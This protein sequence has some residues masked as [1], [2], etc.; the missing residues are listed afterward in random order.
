MASI[1]DRNGTFNP[2]LNVTKPQIELIAFILDYKIK[3]LS[4][5]FKWTGKKTSEC[6]STK[7]TKISQNSKYKIHF[8]IPKI[9][10]VDQNRINNLN[11]GPQYAW[12]RSKIAIFKSEIDLKW[13]IC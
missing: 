2:Q 13:V 12:L 5:P 3:F 4:I 6:K 8:T 7:N 1:I 11:F 9:H 10:F